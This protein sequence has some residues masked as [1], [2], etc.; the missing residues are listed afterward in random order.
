MQILIEESSLDGLVMRLQGMCYVQRNVAKAFN[1]I[2]LL[3]S[4]VFAVCGLTL[5]LPICL[6]V[7]FLF[8][9]VSGNQRSFH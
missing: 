3:Y 1:L 7:C 4:E 5:F 2:T 6:E 9:S 8:I